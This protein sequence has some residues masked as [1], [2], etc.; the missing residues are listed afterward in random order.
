MP[1]FFLGAKKPLLR[2]TL[3]IFQ[4]KMKLLPC[5]ISGLQGLRNCRGLVSVGLA[6][7]RGE[8]AADEHSDH[9]LG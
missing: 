3:S 6:A 2:M 5:F 4:R 1:P 7:W 9:R 8:N